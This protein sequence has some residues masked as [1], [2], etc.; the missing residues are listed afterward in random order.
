[1]TN[2]IPTNFAK[3]QMRNFASG[4]PAGTISVESVTVCSDNMNCNGGS[5]N[6]TPFDLG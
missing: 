1:M 6:P 3:K 4:S 2:D 5:V